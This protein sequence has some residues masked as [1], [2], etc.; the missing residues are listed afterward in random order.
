MSWSR[1]AV[2]RLGVMTPTVA[3][4]N[5]ANLETFSRLLASSPRPAL[6]WYGADGERVELSGKVTENWI[7]KSANLF[8]DEL[9]ATHGDSIR[10]AA[11]QHWRSIVA[12]LGALRAGCVIDP[13]TDRPTF[14]LGFDIDE[15][16]DQAEVAVIM[17]RAALATRY[18][19]GTDDWPDDAIDYCAE[20]RSFGDLFDPID[21]VPGSHGIGLAT[22][23]GQATTVTLSEWLE[24]VAAWCDRA[25]GLGE[26]TDGVVVV[27]SGEPL[28][29]DMLARSCGIMAAG[30]AVVLVD[31]QAARNAESLSSISDDERAVSMD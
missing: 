27:P 9:D 8:V 28:D 5:F 4:Q 15:R 13:E 3:S 29:L 6:I 10:L 18:G 1:D 19:H 2:V 17:D 24:E 22:T 7:A 20:I 26:E 25:S 30:K 12:A 16:A 21:A 11:T 23:D 14:W 31:P